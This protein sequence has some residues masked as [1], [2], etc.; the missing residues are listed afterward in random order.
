[1]LHLLEPNHGPRF[2]ELLDRHYPG[3]REARTELNT[4]PLAPE[5]WA[6]TPGD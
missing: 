5:A 1:M 6:A 4:L 2:I 3:W